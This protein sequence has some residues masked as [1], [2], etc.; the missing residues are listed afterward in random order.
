M[1]GRTDFNSEADNLVFAHGDKRG[2]DL[3]VS[4][5]RA[6]AGEAIEGVVV[7]GAAVGVSGA[8]LLDRK[9]VV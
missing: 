7:G 2:N 8:V 3:D 6:F 5:F 9:S 1:Q 4:F